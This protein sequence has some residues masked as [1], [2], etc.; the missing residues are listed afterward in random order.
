[1]PELDDIR[2]GLA[3]NLAAIPDTQISAY[4]LDNP[5]PGMLQVAGLDEI[6]YDRTY[7]RDDT[8]FVVI[9]GCASLAS[10]DIGSQ[11]RFDRWLASSGA[12]SVKAAVESDKTLTKR[13]QPDG[14]V[15][16]GQPAAADALRVTRFRGYRRQR[17]EN[18]TEV[19]LGDWI[20]QVETS[21]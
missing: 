9:E 8:L 20:V 5:T 13:L 10:G 17:L 21:G 19:L 7:G 12:E 14:T 6:E 4:M 15:Q 3:A 1:M 16:T 11:K 18:G 2:Q